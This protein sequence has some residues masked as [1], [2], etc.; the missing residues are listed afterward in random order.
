MVAL[1]GKNRFADLRCQ[2]RGGG[3][4]TLESLSPELKAQPSVGLNDL[5]LLGHCL[6]GHYH[7]IIHS[8][9]S[10]KELE[11]RES[12][13]DSFSTPPITCIHFNTSRPE[14]VCQTL[15]KF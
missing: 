8:I 7:I 15:L 3:L 9:F 12:H 6:F 4:A 14:K 10:E 13:F 11:K 5:A 2:G 1:C